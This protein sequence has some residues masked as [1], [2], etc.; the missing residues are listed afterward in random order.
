VP[1]DKVLVP[2]AVAP[3]ENVTVPLGVPPPLV[4]VTVAVKV[5]EFPD[6]DGL[7]DDVMFVVVGAAV[8]VW[9]IAGDVDAPY[10]VLPL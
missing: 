6:V 1:P 3:S 8:M 2:S 5:T 4:G 9:V 7:T 10:D